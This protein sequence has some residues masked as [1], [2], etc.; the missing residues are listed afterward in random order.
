MKLSSTELLSILVGFDTTSRNS[1]LE[2]IEWVAGYLADLG[3]QARIL[4]GPDGRK[5]NLFATLGPLD[6]GGVCLHG[7]SDVVPVDGQPWQTDPFRL[8]ERDG[9]CF[10]R[11]TSDMKAWL[12]CALAA[13]AD[14]SS[15]RLLTPIHLA[16][17]YDEEVGCLGAPGLIAPFGTSVPKPYL[18]IVGEPSEMT[19]ITAHKGL[20]AL[21]SVITGVDAHSSMPHLGVS[22]LSAAAEMTLELRDLAREWLHLPGP[23]GMVPSGPTVSVGQLRS[24]VARNVIPGEARL[25]WEIRFRATDSPQ[26]LLEQA[27]QRIESRL[28]E[29][30]AERFSDLTVQTHEVARIPAF[31]AGSG[32]VAER[33][34]RR[35]GAVGKARAVPYGAEA[36][37]YAEAGIATVICG[38]GSIEQAHRA[39]E[40]ITLSQVHACEAFLRRLGELA[41]EVRLGD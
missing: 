29:R 13:A 2:L 15:R 20:L 26:Q 37:Q 23:P 40:F 5:A 12:A 33:L 10:G 34:V 27:R 22:A 19:P 28:R 21:D 35:L 1:N 3:V 31:D 6:R 30:L 18:V 36:G 41:S 9:R 39:N 24:G 25:L 8:V 38:P 32:G 7:H 17:S 16:L 4:H 11:G 14:Y